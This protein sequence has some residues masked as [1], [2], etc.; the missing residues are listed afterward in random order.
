MLHGESMQTK[1]PGDLCHDSMSRRNSHAIGVVWLVAGLACASSVQSAGFTVAAAT[2]ASLVGISMDLQCDD[3]VVDGTLDAS[4][5]VFR[6]V[7]N[8]RIGASGTLTAPH[9]QFQVTHTWQNNGA[10]SGPGSTVT[11]ATVCA[12]AS[13][14]ISGHTAFTNF[15]ATGPGLTLNFAAGREQT[16]SGLLTLH[17]V[18]LLGDGGTAY[19]SLGPGGAQDISSVGVNG[20][21]A[22]R[23]P[24]LAPTEVNQISG[25]A[26]NW[27]NSRAPSVG[28]VIPV[29][30]TGPLGLSLMV[31][32]LGAAA[33]LRRR[34]FGS[35]L[36]ERVAYFV[37]A[38]IKHL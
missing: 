37:H 19:L 4:N 31:L 11:A 38:D 17:E 12:N 7:G 20:V 35:S 22:S 33:F 2:G 1:Q 16:V 27:F 36:S 26:V 6:N 25:S 15:S 29:P 14:T 30:T 8:V 9:A 32:L 23:G 10:F 24:R 3:L 34:W 28:P 5:A 21:D 18:T 13:T